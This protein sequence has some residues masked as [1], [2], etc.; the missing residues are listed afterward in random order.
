MFDKDTVTY[1]SALGIVVPL[2]VFGLLMGLFYVLGNTG[3]ATD[4]NFRPLFTQRTSAIVAIGTNALLINQ[5]YKRRKVNS[6]R[7]IV[8]ATFVLVG[9]WLWQFGRYVF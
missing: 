1:G 3:A 8:L 5:F 4:V 2:V 7:G 9:I 6:M